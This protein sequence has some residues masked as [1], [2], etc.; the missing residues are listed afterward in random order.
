MPVGVADELSERI[1]P[2]HRPRIL[3][4]DALRFEQVQRGVRPATE[5][6]EVLVGEGKKR[7][8]AAPTAQADAVETLDFEELNSADVEA[9]RGRC[10]DAGAAEGLQGGILTGKQV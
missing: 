5:V 4:V 1:E 3:G 10:G 8:Q 2:A 9:L 7:H 6:A